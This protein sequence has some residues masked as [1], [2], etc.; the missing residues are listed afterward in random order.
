MECW[1]E[2]LVPKYIKLFGAMDVFIANKGVMICFSTVVQ[3][4]FVVFLFVN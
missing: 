3:C 1:R 2:N 4:W